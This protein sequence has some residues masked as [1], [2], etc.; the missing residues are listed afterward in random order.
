MPKHQKDPVFYR[1]QKSLSTPKNVISHLALA[2]AFITCCGVLL[3]CAKTIFNKPQSPPSEKAECEK[4]H[5]LEKLIEKLR[6][7]ATSSP[8]SFEESEKPAKLGIST[9]TT[10]EVSKKT[11]ESKKSPHTHKWGHDLSSLVAAEKH[12]TNES[13]IDI[14]IDV[15]WVSKY[16]WRGFD[17]LDDK[18]A[19][20]PTINADL[21]KTGITFNVWTS[22]VGSS[23]TGSTST[24]DAEEWRYT[25]AYKD[26]TFVGEPFMTNYSIFWRFYDFP[27]HASKD[28]DMQEVG[29]TFQWPDLWLGTGIIPNY[30]VFWMWPSQGGGQASSLG[31]FIHTFGLDYEFTL[32]EVK[33]PL[34]FSWDI[35]Y[36]DGVGRSGR[37][38]SHDWSHMTGGLSTSFEFGIG[39]LRP[40]LYYQTSMEDTVNTDDE[41]WFGLSYSFKF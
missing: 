7:K 36:N 9:S 1:K 15:G 5:Q 17:I 28:A 31:G 6:S 19:F 2:M 13:D 23:G 22:Q 39:T 20:Q 18:A 3:A 8:Q 35:T 4:S 12:S 25:V 37:S 11:A 30:S 16:I 33:Q 29:A 21:R 34:T 14:S 32:P 10:N 26:K 38:V 27:N 24:V 40:G 41:L